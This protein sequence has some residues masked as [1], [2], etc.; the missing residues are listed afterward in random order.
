V[1]VELAAD[2]YLPNTIA[3]V[4][5]PLN[6]RTIH[7][8]GRCW[9]FLE[10]HAIFT[11]FPF[12]PISQATKSKRKRMNVR[13]PAAVNKICFGSLVFKWARD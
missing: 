10:G 3:T 11:A 5:A 6:D 1:D 9:I 2:S 13:G 7:A 4:D 8:G 12:P